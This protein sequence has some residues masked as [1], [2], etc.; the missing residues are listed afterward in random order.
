MVWQIM[1]GMIHNFPALVQ[2]HLPSHHRTKEGLPPAGDYSDGICARP[3]VIVSRQADGT[4]LVDLRLEFHTLNHT[5][6]SPCAGSCPCRGGSLTCPYG[7][8]SRHSPQSRWG[9]AMSLDDQIDDGFR[10]APTFQFRG[11]LA[12]RSKVEHT[13]QGFVLRLRSMARRI[14]RAILLGRDARKSVSDW[15]VFF[16]SHRN[17]PSYYVITGLVGAQ[18][19]APGGSKQSQNLQEIAMPQKTRLAMTPRKGLR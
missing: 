8:L 19:I 5:P 12:R 15:Q 1:P 4:A 3:G 2:F 9:T 7:G 18:Y 6:L 17:I 10:L 14:P 16:L 11:I 13:Q